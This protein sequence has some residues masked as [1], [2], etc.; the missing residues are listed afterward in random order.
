MI[1][2]PWDEPEGEKPES[3]PRAGGIGGTMENITERD[4][5]IIAR[6]AVP[7]GKAHQRAA[8]GTAVE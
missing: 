8:K 6:R 2:L 4:D 5:Y 3:P 1:C 7:G